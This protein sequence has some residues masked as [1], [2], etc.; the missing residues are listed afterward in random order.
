MLQYKFNHPYQL[1][2]F[3]NS[4][5]TDTA[6]SQNGELVSHMEG[7][8]LSVPIAEESIIVAA[9]DGVFDN[10]FPQEIVDIVRQNWIQDIT[11]IGQHIVDMAVQAVVEKSVSPWARNARDNGHSRGNMEDYSYANGGKFEE[12]KRMTQLPC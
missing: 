9:S 4:S 2:W 12:G 6:S 5:I 10:L 3:V 7:L 11:T 1:C 8:Y